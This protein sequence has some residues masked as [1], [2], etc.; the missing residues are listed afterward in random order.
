MYNIEDEWPKR[1][2]DLIYQENVYQ[3]KIEII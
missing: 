2:N 1:I 3:K